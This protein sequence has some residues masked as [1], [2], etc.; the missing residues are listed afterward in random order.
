MGTSFARM[1]SR[2][3][4]WEDVWARLQSM[5]VTRDA[6]DCGKKW[7]NF[8]QQFKK[9][10]KFQNLSDGKD[11]FKLAS[12]DRR[13]EGFSFVMDRSVYD[14]MEAM[15]KGDHTI[16]AKNLADT[17]ATGGVQMPAGTGAAG[18]TMATEGGGDTADEEQG[19]TKDSTFSAGSDDG[20]GK[21][22]NMRQQTFEAV[23]NVM[24]KHGAL[25]ASTMDSA[26]KRQ[27]S[28]MSCQCEILESEVEVQMKH[29]AAADESNRMMS[30]HTLHSD[31]IHA[32]RP[33]PFLLVV[34]ESLIS[35]LS[36]STW[37][38]F[39]VVVSS[40]WIFSISFSRRNLL[41]ADPYHAL[42][43]PTSISRQHLLLAAERCTL[44]SS[45]SCVG[46]HQC[47]CRSS[48]LPF[49]VLPL[50]VD[51]SR[52]GYIS[53]LRRS[54]VTSRRSS[55]HRGEVSAGFISFSRSRPR[56]R[57]VR[58]EGE[59]ELLPRAAKALVRR[60]REQRRG[61]K[62]PLTEA[63]NMST[64][65][66]ARGKKRENIPADS[67]G[68]ERAN[69]EEDDDEFTTEEEAAEENVAAPRGSTLQRSCDLSGA[70]RL[71][72]PPPKAQQV[73]AH[74]TQKAKEVVVDVGGEDDEA[75][76]RRR[77][78]N[79]TQGATVTAVRIRAATEERP[80]LGG[81]PLT[82]SQPCLRN[83]AAEGGSMERG[84]G[85]GAQQETHVAGGVAIAAAAAG[86]SG[87]V[88][89]VARAREEVLVVEREAAPVDNNGEREDEDPLLSR[90]RRGGMARDL[91]NCARLW[92]D[93]KAG[94]QTPPVPRSVVMPKSSTTLTRIADPAQLQQAT[95]RATTA[96]NIALRVLHGWVFKSGNRP[97][98]FNVAF[99]YTLESVATDIARVMWNDEEWSKVVSVPVCVHT[100]DLNMDLPL[101]FAG[102]NIEDRPED[103]DMAAH[104][105]STV[106]CIAY[107]FR[108]AVQMGGIVN[109]GFI[110]HERLCRIAD[111]FRLL[112]A[113]CMWLMRMAGDDVRSH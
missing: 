72:T 40:L 43:G 104:K 93:D 23:A 61:H 36:L 50:A 32:G 66:G 22:K 64:H 10:H 39:D 79:V 47:R 8:M 21:R 34:A 24:E 54:A 35:S 53:P 75:L 4:K 1:K 92:V 7:D 80:P 97:R 9:I 106:V 89:V 96:E 12:K 16:H 33:L 13:S 46:L 73:R 5:G 15:T 87:N 42:S 109:G 29:Y 101:W 25:M 68:R 98:G 27:C 18:D 78:R 82:S 81:V 20:Y 70:R 45:P 77:Q 59:D 83:T 103:N 100:I 91:A 67:Q 90:V 94:M 69:E 110:S 31:N 76:E 56:G 60:R 44:A 37:F 52:R 74:N 111:C 57:G 58:G 19:S 71:A 38:V 102:T 30:A 88:G 55:S 99:Q 28:M 63:G 108:T 11:Y 2:E 49:I 26:S 105:E 3:W 48:L 62:R 65:D 113:A 14:E 6:V 51:P 112:L 17:G 41:A 107:A 84:G 85:E 95:A 86:C